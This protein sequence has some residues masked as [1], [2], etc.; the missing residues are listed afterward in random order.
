MMNVTC[1][2]DSLPNLVIVIPAGDRHHSPDRSTWLLLPHP[3]RLPTG[4]TSTAT[5]M[6]TC[7]QPL[8]F[9]CSKISEMTYKQV[10]IGFF[11]DIAE[12]QQAVQSLLSCGFTPEALEMSAQIITNQPG[13]ARPGLAHSVSADEPIQT[14]GVSSGRFF[15]SLYGGSNDARQSGTLVTIQARSDSEGELATDLLKKAGAVNRSKRAE[16]S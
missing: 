14:D 16:A 3:R 11:D 12:A 13:L 4:Y 2:Y 8:A 15:S 10:I 5:A 7:C 6:R 1:W 9:P